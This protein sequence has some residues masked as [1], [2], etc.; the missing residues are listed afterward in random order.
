VRNLEISSSI[1]SMVEDFE[2]SCSWRSDVVEV[3]ARLG[4]EACLDGF[5]V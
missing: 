5:G 1:E 4:E 3:P 2:S